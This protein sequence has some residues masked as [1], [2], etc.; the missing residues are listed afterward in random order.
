MLNRILNELKTGGSY[1]LQELADRFE[2]D[3]P[4]V[5][6]QLEYLE[7][8]GYVKQSILNPSCSKSCGACKLCGSNAP[9]VVI[10]DLVLKRTKQRSKGPITN[11]L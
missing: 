1:T 5:K 10:W 11:L 6:A 2:T 9:A 7:R 3:I 4:T 8:Q